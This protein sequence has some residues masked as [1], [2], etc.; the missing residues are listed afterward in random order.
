MASRAV[1]YVWKIQRPLLEEKAR[2]L[3]A[4]AYQTATATDPQVTTVL[5]RSPIHA[6]TWRNGQLVIDDPHLTVCAKNAAQE[7]RKTHETAHGYTRSME[8]A[9][10]LRTNPSGYVKP[11]NTKDN[12]GKEV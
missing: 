5:I 3:M 4:A 8:D 6:E 7:Q 2:E 1:T 10:L 9:T 12:R 11:D